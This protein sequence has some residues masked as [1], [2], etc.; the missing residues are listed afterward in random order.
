M[1]IPGQ[2]V[3]RSRAALHYFLHPH[4]LLN[5][6]GKLEI[7]YA[8][9]FF[10]FNKTVV[11]HHKLLLVASHAGA[12]LGVLVSSDEQLDQPGDGA[13]L[14]QSAVVGRTQSQVAD[15]TNCG[16]DGEGRFEL[17]HC[18]SIIVC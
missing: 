7:Q 4:T 5:E 1:D 13:L 8:A 12:P 16:L 2:D 3:Q 15:Q 14:P 18:F 9:F 11:T 6:W 10:F 17:E